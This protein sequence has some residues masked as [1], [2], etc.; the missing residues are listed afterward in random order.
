MYDGEFL[1]EKRYGEGKEYNIYGNIEF[2]GIF[3]NG[4]KWNG[5]GKEYTMDKILRF[6]GEYLN[7]EKNEK[8]KEYNFNRN[9]IFEG[10]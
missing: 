8:G 1:N 4:K 10:E 7:G 9:M 3:L 6:D 5:T 2:K